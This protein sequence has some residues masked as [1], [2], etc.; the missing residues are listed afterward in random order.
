MVQRDDGTPAGVA[1]W[2][3]ISV[4][5]DSLRSLAAALRSELDDNVRPRA[6]ELIARYRTG[7]GFGHAMPGD[8]V[9]RAQQAYRDC[10]VAGV[11]QLDALIDGADV[12]IEA[13]GRV[14]ARYGEADALA[15]AR[16]R[17]VDAAL[18]DAARARAAVLPDDPRV[19]PPRVGYR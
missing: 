16:G 1:G 12:L 18:A 10:L 19:A 6:S 2:H 3:E 8:D 15:T 14:A 13:A 9:R 11:A 5:I 7:V 17:A 4:D